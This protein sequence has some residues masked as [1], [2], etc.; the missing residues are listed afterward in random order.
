[1]VVEGAS[2]LNRSSKSA[3]LLEAAAL[4]FTADSEGLAIALMGWIGWI[5]YAGPP[6]SK[7]KLA[8][9]PP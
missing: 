4:F 7:S 6:K 8:A 1:M 5:G 2:K 9:A 3:M